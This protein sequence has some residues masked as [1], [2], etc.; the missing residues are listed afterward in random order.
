MCRKGIVAVD[1]LLVLTC[2]REIRKSRQLSQCKDR[3]AQDILDEFRM[4][5]G[6]LC[7]V[8]FI[9]ALQQRIDGRRALLLE[10]L[11]QILD[12]DARHARMEAK[13]YAC[14]RALIV[15]PIGGDLLAARAER[16]E[17]HG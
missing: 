3:I 9:G 6:F 1:G 15:C 7:D 14:P 4:L 11:R 10:K 12:V 17:R 2:E 5:V 8:F 16:G 13:P